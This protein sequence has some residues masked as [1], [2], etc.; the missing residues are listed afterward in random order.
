MKIGLYAVR[1][2][3]GGTLGMVQAFNND[4]TAIRSFEFMAKHG[5]QQLA[6]VVDNPGDF[7]LYCLGYFDDVSGELAGD[8]RNVCS[9]VDIIQEEKQ[10]G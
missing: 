1:D 3:V 10:N 4:G 2:A 7:T 5:A 8:Y 9:F 6:V